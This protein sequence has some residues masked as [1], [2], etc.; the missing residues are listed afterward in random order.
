VK[1]NLRHTLIGFGSLFIACAFVL[2]IPISETLWWKTLGVH[3]SISVGEHTAGTIGFW[4]NW[5]RH[6]TYSE[7]QIESWLAQIDAVSSWL[8]PTTVEGMEAVFNAAKVGGASMEAKFLGYYL[9]TCLNEQAGILH[10][11]LRYDISSLDSD[12]YLGVANPLDTSLAEINAAI[13]AKHGTHPSNPEFEI[14]KD[15]TDALN[16]FEI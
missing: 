15:L 5:D 3:G 16:N 14:M 2:I 9:A 10:D 11:H 12:N 7:D 4:K 8:G 13:E 1:D 6:G